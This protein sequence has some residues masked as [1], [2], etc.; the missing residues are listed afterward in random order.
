MDGERNVLQESDSV[1]TSALPQ[2]DDEKFFLKFF[3]TSLYEWTTF[4]SSA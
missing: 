4:V 3:S 2:L 1:E